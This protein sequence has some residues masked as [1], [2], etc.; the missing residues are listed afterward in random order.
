[1]FGLYLVAGKSPLAGMNDGDKFE[2]IE[3]K[4]NTPL[5]QKLT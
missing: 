4:R 2:R 1:M 3:M 5:F